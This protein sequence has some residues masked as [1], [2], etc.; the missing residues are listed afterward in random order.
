MHKGV[1]LPR[2]T[3]AAVY[4]SEL[5]EADGKVMHRVLKTLCGTLP[6]R[7]GTLP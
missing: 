6:F 4:C 5:P 3:S 2:V 7:T 1:V